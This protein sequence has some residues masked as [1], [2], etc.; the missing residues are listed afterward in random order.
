MNQRITHRQAKSQQKRVPSERSKMRA[1]KPK[2]K[3][4][5]RAAPRDPKIL[6]DDT[7]VS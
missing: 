4:Q 6:T 2:S 1:D 7:Q 3:S 5:R